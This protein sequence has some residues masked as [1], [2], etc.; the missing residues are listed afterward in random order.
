MLLCNTQF[1]WR[2]RKEYFS[3]SI[4]ILALRMF[5][6]PATRWQNIFSRFFQQDSVLA[7]VCRGSWTRWRCQN[8]DNRADPF[9]ATVYLV[10]ALVPWPLSLHAA[11]SIHSETLRHGTLGLKG[12][13]SC[14]DGSSL[15]NRLLRLFTIFAC[16]QLQTNITMDKFWQINRAT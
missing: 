4:S 10:P 11:L 8:S 7:S 2:W 6:T 16:F 12:N 1:V 5:Q 9:S 13:P 14:L 3:E 15:R